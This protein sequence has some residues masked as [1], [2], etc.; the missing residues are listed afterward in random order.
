[1]LVRSYGVAGEDGD[2]N[3][4][5]VVGDDG[6]RCGSEPRSNGANRAHVSAAADDAGSSAR[7]AQGQVRSEGDFLVAGHP[8]VKRTLPALKATGELIISG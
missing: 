8:G 6:G 7:K 3:Q 2:A 1:M 5:V 4:C